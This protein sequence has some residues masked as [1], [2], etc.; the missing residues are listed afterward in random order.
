[1]VNRWP[2]KYRAYISIR[3]CNLTIL[4]SVIKYILK[5]GPIFWDFFLFYFYI[6][7]Y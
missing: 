1:L 2:V 5:K 6:Y 7:I 4:N 3:L